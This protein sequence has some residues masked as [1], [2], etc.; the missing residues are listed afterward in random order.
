M[1]GGAT[2]GGGGS[3]L[4]K[5]LDDA[6]GQNERTWSG[7]SRG[8]VSDSIRARVAELTTIAC[9][10]RSRAPLYHVHADPDVD[11]SEQQWTRYWQ[12]VEDEFALV[13][14]PYAEAVHLKA[15]RQHRH[16]VYSL[17]K[18]DGTCLRL[19]H[20]YIRREKLHRLVELETGAAIT[21]GRHNRA[22]LA[23]LDAQGL[24]VA[25][26]ELRAAGLGTM[27][28]PA[29]PMTPRER[30][31]AE[32]TGVDPRVVGAA[33]LA[34]WHTSDTGAAF[35]AALADQGLRLAQ[36]DKVPVV[37]DDQGGT[38]PLAKLLAKTAKAGGS[39]PIR[40]AD[41]A[42]RLKGVTLARHVP[43]D[44]ASPSGRTPAT[45][46]EVQAIEPD[47]EMASTAEATSPAT[48]SCIDVAGPPPEG[49]RDLDPSQVD[50]AVDHAPQAHPATQDPNGA[51][52]IPGTSLPRSPEASSMPTEAAMA[53]GD[54]IAAVDPTK[55]GDAAR[56]LRQVNAAHAR[57]M[58]AIA[59]VQSRNRLGASHVPHQR[60]PIHVFD[61]DAD[62]VQSRTSG[63]DPQAVVDRGLAWGAAGDVGPTAGP[64]GRPEGDVDGH[65]RRDGGGGGVG[66]PAAAAGPV[67][68]PGSGAGVEDR[69][70]DLLAGGN[71]GQ[72]GQD[73]G[74]A[75]RDRLAA[76]QVE[77]GLAARADALQRLRI[78]T[79]LLAAPTPDADQP[80]S[81]EDQL[82]V[83]DDALAASDARTA[84]VLDQE[85]WPDARDRDV[86]ALR[87][88]AQ[89]LVDAEVG[90]AAEAAVVAQQRHDDAE[91][92]LGVVDRMRRVTGIGR[93]TQAVLAVRELADEAERLRIKADT[94]SY[95]HRDRLDRAAAQA[96]DLARTR[97]ADR[98]RWIGSGAVVRAIQE[99]HGNDLVRRAIADGDIELRDLAARNLSAARELLLRHEQAQAEP[100]QALAAD[101]HVSDGR[102]RHIGR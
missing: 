56:F 83:L 55:P 22:V 88:A 47:A 101:V 99:R 74:Q 35:L 89:Q 95:L 19:D 41:V 86:R 90:Q 61:T 29:A 70:G 21:P 76:R 43:E 7:S 79:G 1:I 23:A 49:A 77:L 67:D 14:Q 81:P 3:K 62:A 69:R 85:P 18:P 42:A 33:V 17:V 92:Q 9:H 65:L 75:G 39:A 78:L 82:T 40:A 48:S 46:V 60:Q 94:L 93:Q 57:R 68:A 28:R 15:G 27:E 38:H 100:R 5:H 31:Q 64:G 102:L 13:R 24:T 87:L 8:L 32:R 52:S 59:A 66:R 51:R 96:A 12:L 84:R 34:A 72:P 10:A 11:W 45:G 58:A 26:A 30:M 44:T 50:H 97:E 80:G 53:D 54:V 63:S 25:A 71:R 91:R 16:R 36:G 98:R 20:D 73:R 37:V 6:K 4:G 2:R